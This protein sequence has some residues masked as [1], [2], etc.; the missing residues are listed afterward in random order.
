MQSPS[1]AAG[2]KPLFLCLLHAI[3]A[4]SVGSLPIVASQ[5]HVLRIPPMNMSSIA[6]FDRSMSASFSL[7]A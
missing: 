7:Y 4:L 6:Y 5:S 1:L 3:F 2:L